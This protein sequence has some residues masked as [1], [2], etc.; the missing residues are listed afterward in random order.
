MIAGSF[1]MAY[2][3]NAS[4]ELRKSSKIGRT[5]YRLFRSQS[6]NDLSRATN[7]SRLVSEPCPGKFQSVAAKRNFRRGK[8]SDLRLGHDHANLH[9]GI[10]K[11]FLRGGLVRK[12]HEARSHVTAVSDVE[13]YQVVVALLKLVEMPFGCV[14]VEVGHAFAR[15]ARTS[16]RQE[17]FQS[18]DH[19]LSCQVLAT[20]VE[21]QN[22]ERQRGVDR[23]LCLLLVYPEHRKRRLPLAEQTTRIDRSK[24]PLKIH[25]GAQGGGLHSGESPLQCPFQHPLICESCSAFCCRCSPVVLTTDF[26]FRGLGLSQSLNREAKR[27]VLDLGLHHSPHHVSFCRPDMQE[28]LIVFAGDRVPRLCQIKN[29]RSVLDDDGIAGAGKELFESSN[30]KVGRH[31]EIVS[32]HF[33]PVCD[34]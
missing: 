23:G 15:Q 16:G 24:R 26:Q 12:L 28:T 20:S 18:F 30:K 5:Q 11:S 6:E 10:P 25:G 8:H 17:K 13:L 4:H 31:T 34:R 19:R 7:R 14:P 22:S 29:S 2:L 9:D 3:P 32:T 27:L 33:R 1:G 21:P